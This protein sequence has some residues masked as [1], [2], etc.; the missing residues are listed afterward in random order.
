VIADSAETTLIEIVKTDH[1]G[2]RCLGQ[3]GN[4]DRV[5]DAIKKVLKS[6][7]CGYEDKDDGVITLA[8]IGSNKAIKTL[9]GFLPNGYV[10]GGWIAIKINNRDKLGIIPQLWLAQ[11]QLYCEGLSDAIYNIQQREGLYNPQFSDRQD[12][13]LFKPSVLYP[14][15]REVLLEDMD[16]Y[17]Q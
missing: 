4:S 17:D 5:I 13:K 8:E 1:Q 11:K 14:R 15:L 9:L 2:I 3:I 10:L 6:D 12:Y 16:V 7:S